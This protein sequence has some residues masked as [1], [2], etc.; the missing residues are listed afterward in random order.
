M[1]DLRLASRAS[2]DVVQLRNA[3]P[4]SAHRGRSGAGRPR[5]I[6]SEEIDPFPALLGGHR[7]EGNART[8]ADDL[9]RDRCYF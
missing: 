2:N 8:G 5:V 6:W 9:A 7:R 3:G 4:A 1:Q